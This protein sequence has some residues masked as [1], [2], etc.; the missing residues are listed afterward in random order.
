MNHK[1]IKK[2][3]DSELI[4]L[5]NRS[6]ELLKNGNLIEAQNAFTDLLK[7]HFNN[8][9]AES[10]LKCCKYWLIR[11]DKI[12]SFKDDVEK[13]R[14]LFIEWKKFE[15][16]IE[17]K[18]KF[19]KKVLSSIM[20]FVHKKALDYLK[21][22][23][24]SRIIDAEL[25]YLTGIANKKIGDYKN[26]IINFKKALSIDINNANILAQLADSYALIDEENKAKLLFREAF[27]IEP[28][29]IDIELLDSNIIHTII[30]KLYEMNIPQ[31]EIKYWI[32]VYGRVFEVFN[33]YRELIPVEY[34]RLKQEIFSLEKDIETEF[35]YKNSKKARLI[36]YYLWL[37]DYFL[38]KGNSKNEILY[39][40]NNI[41]KLSN[42]IYN[43]LKN[44]Q[45]IK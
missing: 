10:G 27:F 6:L 37:Y 43:L 13:G 45:E 40:E 30:S 15:I 22:N 44:K 23:L 7:I 32:P 19:N 42:D 36:N 11:F 1:N 18:N 2:N 4:K 12:E 31:Q 35:C 38:I 33:I 5:I 8:D 21:K 24:N 16:F 26:A 39:I 34:G 17:T 25:I 28:D 14:F 9:I 3:D 29:I 20:F 41:K